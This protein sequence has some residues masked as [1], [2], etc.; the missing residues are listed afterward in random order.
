MPPPARGD[1]WSAAELFA[2]DAWIGAGAPG[3][4]TDMCGS[5]GSTATGTSGTVGS[6]GSTG[7]PAAGAGGAGMAGGSA[8]GGGGGSVP[9]AGGWGQD[10]GQRCKLLAH[11]QSQPGGKTKFKVSTA[12]VQTF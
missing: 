10:F 12:P 7:G 6:G 8:G 1:A 11:R 4:S 2:L 9:P 5:S 3:N